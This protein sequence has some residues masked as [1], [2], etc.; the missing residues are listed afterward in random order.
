[1]ERIFREAFNEQ[2]I[3]QVRTIAYFSASCIAV[4]IFQCFNVYYSI[5]P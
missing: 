4:I 2:K 5:C 3:I 1:M